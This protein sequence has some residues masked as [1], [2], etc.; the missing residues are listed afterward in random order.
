MW[1]LTN[2]KDEHRGREKREKE[3]E[4]NHKRLLIIENKLR[5]DGRGEVGYG[6]D[7]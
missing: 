1:N 6:L 3:R 7:G 5:V 2:K 4:G